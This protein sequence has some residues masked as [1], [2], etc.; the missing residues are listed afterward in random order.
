MASTDWKF[1]GKDSR[2]EFREIGED[3]DAPEDTVIQKRDV[4]IFRRHKIVEFVD[5]E[6]TLGPSTPLGN[7]N[8]GQGVYGFQGGAKLLASAAIA[9]GNRV[10]VHTVTNQSATNNGEGPNWITE[11][12]EWELREE[13]ENFDWP[14]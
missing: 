14:T 8:S 6:H 12:E 9:G 7:T 5:G 4:L 1:A 10:W 11:T 2:I 3:P 13:W